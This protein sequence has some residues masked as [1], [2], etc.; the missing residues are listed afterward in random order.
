[1]HHD[2][3][4]Q[5][6]DSVTLKDL[7][8]VAETIAKLAPRYHVWLFK[9]DMGAGKT[10]LIKAVGAALGVRDIMSSPTFSIVNQYEAG[11]NNSIY[12]FDFYRIRSE[13]EAYDIGADEYFYSG[14][15]CFIEWPEKIPSLIPATHGSVTI[16]PTDSTHRTIVITVHDG[17]EE[18]RI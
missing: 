17:E 8:T 5:V 4:R 15:P 12:H 13:A 11:A 7:T 2:P 16:Q 10:T 9:G 3:G 14:S 18:N 1:M 6:F